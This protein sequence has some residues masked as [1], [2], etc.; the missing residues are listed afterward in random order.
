MAPAAVPAAPEPTAHQWSHRW[1]IRHR[2]C[3][4]YGNFHTT[5]KFDKSNERLTSRVPHFLKP[6]L[7]RHFEHRRR[8]QWRTRLHG[9]QQNSECGVQQHELGSADRSVRTGTESEVGIRQKP[10]LGVEGGEGIGLGAGVHEGLHRHGHRCL[11][12]PR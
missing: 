7:C 2:S 1:Q 9:R 11:L 6:L 5:K 4:R 12:L 10:H 8:K 3:H